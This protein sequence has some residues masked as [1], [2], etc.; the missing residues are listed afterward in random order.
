MRS[1]HCRILAL[2]LVSSVA[3]SAQKPAGPAKESSKATAYYHYS[4][5]HMYAE[6]AAAYGNRGEY[7]NKAIENYRLA[8]KADPEATFLTEELSDL[9]IQAGRLRDAVTE[10]EEVLKQNPNDLN[11][12]RILARIYTRMIGDAQQGKVDQ[13]MVTKAIEQYQKITEKAPKDIDSLL[14]LGRL[15]KVAGSNTDAE[16]AFRKA[17]EIDSDSEDATT[18]LASVLADLGDTK[19][20]ADLLR[21][22]SEKNPTAR[23]LLKLAEAYEQMKDYPLAAESLKKALALNPP[24]AS[25]IKRALAQNLL[26]ADQLDQSLAVYEELVVEEPRDLGSWLRISQI[27]RQ[28]RKFDK[29]REAGAKAKELDANNLEIRYNDVNLLE[30][31]GKTTA[32]VAALKE[33]LASTQ[34]RNY[35]ASDRGNRVLLLERLGQLYR[36]IEQTENAADTFKQI[37]EVDPDYAARAATQVADTYR[38]GKEYAK[39]LQTSE[40]GLKKFPTDRTLRLV[41]ANILADTGKI[42]Q[43]AGEIRKLLDGKSDRDVYIN[44]AQIYEKAKRF[45]EMAKSLDEADKLGTGKEDKETILFMRGAMYERQK[46]FDMAEAEFRKLLES[47]P[48]N[49]G[50]LNY[51]GY[52]LADRNV[53]LQEAVDMIQKAVD[54]EPGNSAYLDSLGWAFF[55]LG[56]YAEAEDSL[57]RSLEKSSKDPTIHDHLGDVYF[58]QGKLK[59]AI[60]QW[61]QSIKEWETGSPAELDQTEVAKVQRKLESAKVRLAKETGGTKP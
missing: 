57:R 55:R 19:G 25:D 24:N 43:A 30:A 49:A 35:S 1:I 10:T 3:A 17:L 54:K 51:L 36:S 59:E 32:A 53:R 34:R 4:L 18:G 8:V 47:N 56:R 39:A 14:M 13:S 29:A 23:G 60:N 11:A 27:Y 16:K 6:L 37:G 2:I 41:H 46:K 31:E 21:K 38:Q 40:A 48:D 22:V 58:K 20:A 28:Q 12:R 61:T 52:M 9:Y 42:D 50:A 7:F 26:F 5:G 44:L 45:D 15:Q 33:I